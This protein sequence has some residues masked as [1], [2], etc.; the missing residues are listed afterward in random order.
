MQNRNKLFTSAA[1]FVL[2]LLSLAGCQKF[3]RPGLDNLIFD[4]PPPPYSIL[5][6]FW[7]F[8]DNVGDSG[9]YR[10]KPK[11]E[12]ITYETGVNGKA[13]H[14]GNDGYIS[15]AILNDSLKTPGNFTV[16]FWMKGV[17]PVQGGAQGLFAISNNTEFWGNFEMFLENLNN[18]S[19]AFLKVHLFN[20]SASDQKGEVWKEIKIPNFLDKWSHV[21]VTYSAADSKL[22]IYADGQPT[23]INGEV[24][25]GGNYGPLVWKNVG[26]IV[27]GTFAFQTDPS[28]TNHGP[29]SWAKSFNGSL[30]QFRIY[31]VTLSA[32][33][34]NQLYTSKD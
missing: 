14:I 26:G 28:L 15:S 29:E 16:A 3:D 24:L 6:S 20:S 9:Q 4:P 8:E 5:K 18:G 21:A 25:D 13:A 1:L 19:E 2:V 27:L 10:V 11:A 32:A 23:A 7:A 31:N 17:G 33:Q 34:V 12:A 30:D 22:S